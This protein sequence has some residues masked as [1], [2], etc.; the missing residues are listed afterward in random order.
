MYLLVVELAIWNAQNIA[1]GD[2]T[3]NI[4][5]LLEWDIPSDLNP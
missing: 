3:E 4:C 5:S 2:N 1:A